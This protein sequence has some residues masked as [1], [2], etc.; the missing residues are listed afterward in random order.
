MSQGS[1]AAKTACGLA[2]AILVLSPITARAADVHGKL[3]D[4]SGMWEGSGSLFDQSKGATNANAEHV[5]DFPPYNPEWEAKYTRFLNDVV[6]Q[7]KYIDPITL[8]LPGGFPRIMSAPRGTAFIVRPEMVVI[9]KEQ[10]WARYIYTDGRDFP[11]P[12]DMWPT[13]EGWSKGR[14]EGD[15]LVV[16]TRSLRGK[17]AVDRTGLSFSDK[18]TSV[19]RIRRRDDKTMEDRITITDPAALT[20]PWTVT[21]IWR[22]QDP[23]SWMAANN[24]SE[25]QRNPIVD[26]QNTVTVGG[27]DTVGNYPASIAR[28]SVF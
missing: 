22:K 26:G 7:D 16:E 17:M 8:C 27:G 9:L 13:W 21:R 1:S 11:G 18:M 2:A 3:P 6:W 14:W 25:S 10:G 23:K 28:F 20:R 15:T 24:C 5:R 19:E 12:D 4:F